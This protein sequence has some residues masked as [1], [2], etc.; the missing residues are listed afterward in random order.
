M[1][2]NNLNNTK[3]ECRICQIKISYRAGSTNNLHRHIRTVHPTVQL[4]EKRQ[5]SVPATEHENAS[6]STGTVAAAVSTATP[7]ASGTPRPVATQSSISQYMP[8]AMTPARQNTVDEELAKMIASDFQPFSIVEDKGFRSYSH[9][10]NPMYVL[11]S[12]KTLSQTTIP[13]LYDRERASLQERVQKVTAVCLTTDCWTSRT[14]TS[15]MSVTCHFIENYKMVSCLLDCFEFSDRHTSE[16]LAEELLRVAK[17]W[18]VENKV[19][20]CVSDNAANITKAIKILKWTHHPCLAQTINLVV[21][22]GLKVMKPTLD[23]VKAMVEFFHK[24]TIATEKLK[25]TQRQM[26]MPELRPKQ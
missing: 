7:Q 24:S 17:E 11:P 26:G 19:V 15:F 3:S 1:H 25:S 16:N 8:K 12:R 21:R 14:T 18:Q 10:L 23:K 20:C 13:R 4:E 22:D 9:A 2:F 5:A 6:A